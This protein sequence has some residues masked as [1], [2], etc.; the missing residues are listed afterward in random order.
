MGCDQMQKLMP[1]VAVAVCVVGSAIAD[2]ICDP[3]GL[4]TRSVTTE[5]SYFIFNHQHTATYTPASLGWECSESMVGT[6]SCA[7]LSVL[8]EGDPALSGEVMCDQISFQWS[9]LGL[10]SPFGFTASG[11]AN[12][13][14]SVEENANLAMVEMSNVGSLSSQADWSI[15]LYDDEDRT[16]GALDELGDNYELEA[17]RIYRLAFQIDGL[18]TRTAL[19]N[20][21]TWGMMIDYIQ[22]QPAVVPGFGG[23]ALFASC[24]IPRRRRRR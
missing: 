14:F 23:L 4:Q 13:C 16:L 24:A 3:F 2:E 11:F 5:T 10:Y 7:T 8:N 6:T 18:D 21:I 15:T 22:V 1:A 17:D 9:N 20:L 19:G 12:T